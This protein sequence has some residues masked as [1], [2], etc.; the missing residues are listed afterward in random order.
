VGGGGGGG[1]GGGNI[2]VE[3]GEWEGGMGCGTIGGW[4]GVG[5]GINLECKK[6]K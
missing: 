4:T 3:T 2:L 6:Y 5:V 1:G